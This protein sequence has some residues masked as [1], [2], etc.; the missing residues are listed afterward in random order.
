MPTNL[1]GYRNVKG[2]R[3]PSVTTILGRF[4]ESGALMW[5]SNRLAYEPYRQLR[6][7]L[8]QIVQIGAV[9]PGILAD[10]RDVLSKPP[11][12]CDY[13]VARD[14][15]ANIGTVV[16]HRVD[17][18]IRGAPCDLGQFISEVMPDPEKAS[19]TGFRAFLEWSGAT[20]FQMV[21]GEVQLVSNE[22]DFGG[23]PD[24]VLVRGERAIGDF[25]TG[26][27]YVDQVLPQI[28]AYR[29]LVKENGKEVGAGGHAISINKKTGGFTHRFFTHEEMD[30]G[31]EVFKRMRELYGLVKELK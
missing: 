23:C 28:A 24:I 14:S 16:H 1:Q 9:S 25:K 8:E 4:R 10:I 3:V 2:E 19:E 27:L 21:E 26:D 5:W 11:D 31:W 13:R 12:H 7:I 30:K 15:A 29:Q 22:Y 20:S 17:S 18:H 6:A